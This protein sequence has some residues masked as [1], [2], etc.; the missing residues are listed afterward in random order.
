MTTYL[1]RVEL[2]NDSLMELSSLSLKS[3]FAALNS[4]PQSECFWSESRSQRQYWAGRTPPIQIC[5]PGLG[6]YGLKSKSGCKCRKSGSLKVETE[7]GSC[8][9]ALLSLLYCV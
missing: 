8:E 1:L 3:E 6:K 2:K 9:A 7:R 5:G 4:E